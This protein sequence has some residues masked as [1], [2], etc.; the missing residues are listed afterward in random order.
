MYL[1]QC[2][3]LHSGNHKFVSYLYKSISVICSMFLDSTYKWYHMNICLFLS[4][5]T[6]HTIS[7]SIHVPENDIVSYFHGWVTFHSI[8]VPHLLCSLLCWWTFHCFHI[9]AIVNSVA[10]NIGVHI[11]FWIII[12]LD[13]WTGVVFLGD[14]GAL[15]IDF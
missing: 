10:M 15:F 8:Y 6:Q 12:I 3:N 1:S 14:R 4:P 9:L 2:L 5:F 7:R 11:S 13:I